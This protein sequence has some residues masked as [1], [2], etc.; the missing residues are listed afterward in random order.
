MPTLSFYLPLSR[1]QLLF[2]SSHALSSP[3]RSL[4]PLFGVRDIT[5]AQLVLKEG[6]KGRLQDNRSVGGWL[7]SLSL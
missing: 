7:K 2:L 4:N 5:T 3:L 6:K 1:P